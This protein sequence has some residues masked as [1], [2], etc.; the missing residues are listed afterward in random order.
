MKHNDF[1]SRTFLLMRVL[2]YLVFTV[3]VSRGMIL[4]VKRYGADWV[5]REDA[6][7]EG[8]EAGLLAASS[9]LL[10][11]AASRLR[12]VREVSIVFASF[13]AMAVVRE[14]DGFWENHI[15]HHD[16]WGYIDLV[17]LVG[18]LVYAVPRFSAI[19]EQAFALTHSRVFG[20]L[21]CG[22]LVIMGFSR[23]MGTKGVWHIMLD[24]HYQRGPGRLME[25]STELLGYLMILFGAIE[26]HFEQ[27]VKSLSNT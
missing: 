22:F 25:E 12:G 16:V 23:F 7:V 3:V 14:L 15:F 8:T 13:L 10:F 2:L 21:W 9:L 27:P 24:P 26:L 5:F 1:R 18:L 11:L 6:P 17:L 4:L 19:K 20:F